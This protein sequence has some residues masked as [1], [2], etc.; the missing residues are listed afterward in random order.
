MQNKN[1]QLTFLFSYFISSLLSNYNN[2]KREVIRHKWQEF[3][4]YS[5]MDI[6]NYCLKT[7]LVQMINMDF[8]ILRWKNENSPGVEEL[9]KK[10]YN[11][12]YEHWL[13]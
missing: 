9:I 12:H 8:L 13:G 1:I 5:F 6:L 10:V 4:I 7:I 2:F 3:H 11:K